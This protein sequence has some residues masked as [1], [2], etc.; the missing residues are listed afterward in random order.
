MKKANTF[1]IVSMIAL[2]FMISC[3]HQPKE[4]SAATTIAMKA[5]QNSAT[6]IA[7]PIMTFTETEFD[8]GTVTEGD[9]LKHT[10]SFTNTGNAPLVIVNAKGSCGCTVSDW[11]K[12]P[13]APGETK[14][15]QVAFNTNGK[16]NVQNKQVTITTNT[17]PGKHI[18]KIKAMVTPKVKNAASGV[19]ISK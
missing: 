15:M 4:N 8:F 1:L 18:L 9:I 12:E 5:N 7:V 17:A 6:E 19:P 16:P 14:E 2:G 3:T 13:I 10:F 11:P